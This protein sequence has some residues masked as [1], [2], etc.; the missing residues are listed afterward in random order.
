[1]LLVLAVVV[2]RISLSMLV[3]A[4]ALTKGVDDPAIR[5]VLSMVVIVK[6]VTTSVSDS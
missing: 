4:G 2:A 1:M 6:V 5:V 3:L